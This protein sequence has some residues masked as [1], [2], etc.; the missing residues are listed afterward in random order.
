MLD[1]SSAES[2]AHPL[3]DK[4]TADTYNA[5]PDMTQLP[6]YQQEV[7]ANHANC[8]DTISLGYLFIGGGA[9]IWYDFASHFAFI[10]DVNLLGGIGTSDRQ[11][12]FNIDVQAGLGVHF[13]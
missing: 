6:S 13:L 4:F 1:I 3:V 9:G 8:S 12:G 7:C 2:E 5:T 11:S 10:L